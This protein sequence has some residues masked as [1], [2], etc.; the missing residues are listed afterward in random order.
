MSANNTPIIHPI[1]SINF[2]CKQSKYN[3][4]PKLPMRAML[5][6]PSGSG[7]TVLLQNL[8]LDIYKNCFEM[9]YIFS[10]SIH[11]DTIW[12]PVIKYIEE[13]LK[14]NKDETYL[15][16][17]YNPQDLAFILDQQFKVIEYMKKHGF[18]KLYNIL[19]IVDDFADDISFT[20]NSKLLH[21]L[22]IG[23]RHSYISTIVS[24]QVYKAISSII[25]KNIT[26][27]FVFKLRN[28]SDL[29][30]LLDEFGSV[31]DKQTLLKMYKIATDPAFSF[32]YINLMERN[33][34]DIF[35]I[36]FEKKPIPK[37]L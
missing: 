20:R 27:L 6:G 19:I 16:D 21:Q 28:Y 31:Y 25:R 9:I 30:A 26:H 29:E 8:I 15:F 22:F 11:I 10:P 36:S 32:L 4:V 3:R 24:T 2:E 34:E 37:G 35:Y 5:L 17:E 14:P 33:K 7:K 18:K 12:K 1:K 13:E 23:G